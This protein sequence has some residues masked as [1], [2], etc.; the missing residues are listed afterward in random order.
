[1]G[2]NYEIILEGKK[3]NEWII[4]EH[5]ENFG[6]YG[7]SDNHYF[8]NNSLFCNKI[9]DYESIYKSDDYYLIDIKK[10]RTDYLEINKKND[11][12]NILIRY[13]KSVESIDLVKDY[14]DELSYEIEKP[15]YFDELE[16]WYRIVKN[17][18]KLGYKEMRLI[19]GISS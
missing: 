5:Y 7:C 4:L 15:L 13:I 1:M 6:S 16:K 3:G 2:Y 12:K 17:N 11:W 19:F 9:N 14:V 18:E 8:F 10:M